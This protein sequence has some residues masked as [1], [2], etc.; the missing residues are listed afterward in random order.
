M[1]CSFEDVRVKRCRFINA[2]FND[3]KLKDMDFSDS[4]ISGISL[5]VQNLK[6]AVMNSSQALACTRLLGITIKD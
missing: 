3:T 6:G 5:N 1:S 4:D 2:D